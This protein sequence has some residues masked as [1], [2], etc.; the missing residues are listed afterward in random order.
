MACVVE[1]RGAV[2]PGLADADDLAHHDAVVAAV[3]DGGGPALQRGERVVEDGR[4]RH[5]ARVMPEGI[6]LALERP[7]PRRQPAGGLLPV[8]VQHRHRPGAGGEHRVVEAGDLLRAEQDQQRLQGHRGE[9][10]H[11][12]RVT[13]PVR[14]G[15][16]HH[17]ATGEAAGGPPEVG[18]VHRGHA[19]ARRDQPRARRGRTSVSTTASPA[20]AA[21]P[22]RYHLPAAVLVTIT[23]PAAVGMVSTSE[24]SSQPNAGI[25]APSGEPMP[26][27]PSRQVRKITTHITSATTGTWPTVRLY[28]KQPISPS[29][30]PSRNSAT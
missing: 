2:R 6:E 9:G 13:D 1:Q 30:A 24:A 12:H 10:G 18:G 11:R 27:P 29:M 5:R 7:P 17:D 26:R 20:A 16:H 21:P 22:Y 25:R 28:W 3:V 14:R 15:G 23:L 8:L 4:G 19:P